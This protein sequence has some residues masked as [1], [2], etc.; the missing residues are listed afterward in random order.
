[1]INA[2]YYRL[3]KLCSILKINMP[4]TIRVIERLREM[5]WISSRTHM[6]PRGVKTS[7]DYGE[8][9]EVLKSMSQQHTT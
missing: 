2:P 6:D 8:L 4:S 1:M 5:G 3:D 7:A 9:V